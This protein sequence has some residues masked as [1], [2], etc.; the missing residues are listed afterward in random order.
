MVFEASNDKDIPKLLYT[1]LLRYFCSVK[2]SGLL[3][4]PAA[5]ANKSFELTCK[6]PSF[7]G[8]QAFEHIVNIIMTFCFRFS[9]CIL[10]CLHFKMHILR[11]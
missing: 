7:F 9:Q 10:H 4:I 1:M 11:L 5:F 6:S 3:K 2:H 8:L